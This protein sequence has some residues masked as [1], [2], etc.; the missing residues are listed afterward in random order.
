MNDEKVF[1]TWD[2]AKKEGRVCDYILITR[3][4]FLIA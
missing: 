4:K 3:N 2:A 1:R